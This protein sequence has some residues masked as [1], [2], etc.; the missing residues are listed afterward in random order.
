MQSRTFKW[1][2]RTSATL[3]AQKHSL[4]FYGF[5]VAK[6]IRTKFKHKKFVQNRIY[7]LCCIKIIAKN[8][9]NHKEDTGLVCCQLQWRTVASGCA[10]LAA[11]SIPADCSRGTLLRILLQYLLHDHGQGNSEMTIIF[12]TSTMDNH[13]NTWDNTDSESKDHIIRTSTPAMD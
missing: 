13:Y 3:R 9:A 1:D 6:I 7:K 2:L 12:K 11:M 10:A 4:S 5:H 8:V